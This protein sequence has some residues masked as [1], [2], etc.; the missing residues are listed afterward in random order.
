MKTNFIKNIILSLGILLTM[1][2]FNSCVKNEQTSITE[3]TRYT[4]DDIKSYADLFK[5]FWTVMDQRY[6]YF[7]EQ[8]RKDGMDWDAIYQKYYPKFAELK[9]FNKDSNISDKEMQAE[10]DKAEQY[11]KEIIDPIIDQHFYVKITMKN[12][13]NTERTSTFYGGMKN[14]TKNNTYDFDSKYGYMKDKLTGKDTIFNTTTKL[15]SGNL[16]SNPDI[17]YITFKSFNLSSSKLNFI[18]KYLSPDEGNRYILTSE[19]IYKSQELNAIKDVNYRNKIRD[20]SIDLLNKYNSF[21]K[22]PEATKFKDLIKEFKNTEI[23]SNDFQEIADTILHK[24]RRLYLTEANYNNFNTFK[25]LKSSMKDTS[26]E[27]KTKNTEYIKWFMKRIADHVELGYGIKY[28]GEAAYHVVTKSFFYKHF[29]NPLHNGQIKKIIID[30]R[31]NGG[32]NAIDLRFF[33]DRFITKNVIYGYQRTKEGNG[34][35]N[36]TPWIPTNTRIH[37]FGIPSN[38][39]IVILTDK[40]SASMSEISTLMIKSQ[41]PH[42]MSIGDYST[43]ATAGLSGNSDEFNGGTIDVVTHYLKFYMPLMATKTASGEIIEGVGIKPDIYVTP[44]TNQE[45]KQMKNTPK[46][47]VDRVIVEAINYLSSK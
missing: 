20:F 9:Y 42:V 28:F 17:Y 24:Y 8:K 26:E 47:F 11:F 10:A 14:E 34:R 18:D 39:P 46:I 44:P 21:L 41:G 6:N 5:V 3:P 7:Y 13:Y 43:G 1:E 37:K 32:G 30:F 12:T 33:V 25:P 40:K 2:V 22:S 15:L 45:V 16:K 31:G 4:N 23:I 38:I 29:L 19:D 36:Y 27:A 35:F